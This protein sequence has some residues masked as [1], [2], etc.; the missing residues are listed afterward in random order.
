VIKSNHQAG[1]IKLS[2]TSN[3]L[4]EKSIIIKSTKK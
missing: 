3:G 1:D 2:V 4:E